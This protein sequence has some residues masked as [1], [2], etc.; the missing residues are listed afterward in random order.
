M[1]SSNRTYL[2]SNLSITI[3]ESYIIDC[4][5]DHEEM[6]DNFENNHV[7]SFYVKSDFYL[8]L[9][10]PEWK[11]RGF[12]MYV[13]EDFSVNIDDLLYLKQIF[14]QLLNE[15]YSPDLLTKAHYRVDS[16][17]LMAKTL[18]AVIHNDLADF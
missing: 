14:S 13:V 18:R 12:Q 15:G 8:V 11:D 2:T 5:V 9:Y 4:L 10:F 17:I 6:P 1:E 3:D 16:I 7:I